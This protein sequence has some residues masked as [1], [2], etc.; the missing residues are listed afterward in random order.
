MGNIWNKPLNDMC[1]YGLVCPD[2]NVIKYIGK[3][4]NG[5]KRIK[6]HWRDNKKSK[7]TGSYNKKQCW[8]FGL[9]KNNKKFLVQYL[10]YAKTNEELNEK[11]MYWISFYKNLGLTLLNCTNGG[12]N[13][14]T[15]VYTAEEKVELSK[16]TKEAMWR[17]DIRKNYLEGRKNRIV[18]SKYKSRSKEKKQIHSNSK[19]AKSLKISIIDNFG[20]TYESVK[21]CATK[22]EVSSTWILKAIKERFSVKNL[23]LKKLNNQ[24]RKLNQVI[25]TKKVIDNDGIIY[26]SVKEACIASKLSSKTLT[27]LLQKGTTSKTGWSF[28][29]FRG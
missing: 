29:E 15:H 7:L 19:Y 27:R 20:N 22:L 4:K 13:V 17:P 6:G 26:N 3:T 5:I 11:E 24:K 12:E 2:T 10:D 21:D 9:K 28:K 1:I 25:T 18:P 23:F 16:R 14:V 8:V